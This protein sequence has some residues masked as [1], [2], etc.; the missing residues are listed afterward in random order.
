M[1]KLLAFV[2]FTV[3]AINCSAISVLEPDFEY[4]IDEIHYTVEF[5]D[6]SVFS[7]EQQQQIA[8]HIVL[9][10]D[11]ISTYAWCWLTGHDYVTEGVSLTQ[12]KVYDLEPR[13]MKR[14]YSVKT[15]TKCDFIEETLVSEVLVACCPEE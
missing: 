15:C 12:H 10:D 1:K 7:N 2:L 8:D 3:L 5:V 11:G 14:T 13:C 4:F 6:N 9:G